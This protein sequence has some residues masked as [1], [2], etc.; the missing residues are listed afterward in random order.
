MYRKL[1]AHKA[2]RNGQFYRFKGR[3]HRFEKSKKTS[4]R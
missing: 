4:K 2:S 3:D 1:R